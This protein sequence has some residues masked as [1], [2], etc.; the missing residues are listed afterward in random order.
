M[1]RRM[2]R[3]LDSIGLAWTFVLRVANCQRRN[4]SLRW[5]CLTQALDLSDLMQQGC[6]GRAAELAFLFRLLFTHFPF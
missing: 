3:A 2:V 1:E 5:R 6:G 4:V